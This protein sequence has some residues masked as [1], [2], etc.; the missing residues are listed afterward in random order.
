MIL[1]LGVLGY[2]FFKDAD[3]KIKAVMYLAMLGGVIGYGAAVS[4]AT[5]N[6]GSESYRVRVTVIDGQQT[7]VSD[8]KVWSSIGGEP[9]KVEGG[10]Q[11]VIP[12]DT[13]PR[14]SISVV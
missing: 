12:K 2:I 10:W 9:M 14:E 5:S 11:F 1:F 7:P 4:R 3:A 8:A 13:K 6:V